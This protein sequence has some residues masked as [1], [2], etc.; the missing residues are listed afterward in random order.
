VPLLSSRNSPSVLQR[1]SDRRR[2]LALVGLAAAAVLGAK[3]ARRRG[4]ASVPDYAERPAPAA[5]VVPAPE[6]VAAT[7]GPAV[8]QPAEPEA[9][10]ATEPE[11]QAA[12]A[13][14]PETPAEPNTEELAAAEIAVLAILSQ[15]GRLETDRTALGVATTLERE[16]AEVAVLLRTLHR[17][18]HVAGDEYTATGEKIWFVTESGTGRLD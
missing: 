14:E 13:A 17:Q 3:A 15:D 4:A 9:P 1:L 2:G 18:G 11:P 7:A 6:A 10:V 8:D 16:A 12:T 5:P